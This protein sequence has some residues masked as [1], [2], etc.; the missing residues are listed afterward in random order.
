MGNKFSDLEKNDSN[1]SPVHKQDKTSDEVDTMS[2]AT[3]KKELRKRGVAADEVL[4]EKLREL[5][6]SETPTADDANDKQ[7]SQMDVDAPDE[8]PTGNYTAALPT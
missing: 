3:L 5:R 4:R 6:E 2:A 8:A 7:F 1:M